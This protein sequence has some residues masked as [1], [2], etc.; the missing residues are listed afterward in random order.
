MTRKCKKTGKPKWFLY[1]IVANKQ[2]GIDCDKFDYFARDCANVGVKSTFDHRRYFKNVRIM[3]VKNQ[4]HIC[5]RDKEVFNLYEL[6]HTRWSFH[7]RV[8][9]HKTKAPIE[10]LLAKALQNVDQIMGIS[11]AVNDM[12]R[13]TLLTDSILYDILRNESEECAVRKAKELIR[14]IQE[15]K[16]YKFCGQTQP[17]SDAECPIKDKI[18]KEL[19]EISKGVIGTEDIFVSI[20]EFSYG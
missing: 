5:V 19:A 13:Y 6:F 17:P 4:L 16:I 18:E 11:E 3:P 10:H 2:N 8:C 7:H 12:K 20:V 14:R 1:E 15:R 9:Q